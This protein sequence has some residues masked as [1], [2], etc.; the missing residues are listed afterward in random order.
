MS[1][2]QTV[3]C[4]F[5]QDPEDVHYFCGSNVTA[6]ITFANLPA[7]TNV[8]KLFLPYQFELVEI[9]GAPATPL[10][11]SPNSFTVTNIDDQT[12]T[13]SCLEAQLPI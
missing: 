7:G 4:N 5:T 13:I 2:G 12:I 9:N 10:E 1:F 8:F 11:T 6:N 3:N